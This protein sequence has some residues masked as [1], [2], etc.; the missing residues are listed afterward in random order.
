MSSRFISVIPAKTGIP[1]LLQ[2]G[3]GKGG[4]TPAFAGVTSS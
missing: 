2:T 3:A 1:L 4:G